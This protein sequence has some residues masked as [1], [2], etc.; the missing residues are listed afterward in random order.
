VREPQI[1]H[2]LICLQF[3]LP[4][5]YMERFTKLFSEFHTFFRHGWCHC[6]P[7]FNLPFFFVRA[8]PHATRLLTFP[9]AITARQFTHPNGTHSYLP[10][11]GSIKV[12]PRNVRWT[13]THNETTTRCSPAATATD[14]GLKGW[15]IGVRFPA[16]AIDF[17]FSTA[18]T[19]SLGPT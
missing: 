12:T 7:T 14:H 19:P 6:F 18:S 13:R 5:Y 1:L 8:L 2:L 11:A 10:R 16:T 4:H 3:F 9:H 15:G 17:L